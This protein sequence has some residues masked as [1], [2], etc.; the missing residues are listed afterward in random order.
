M[1]NC[2]QTAE[3][4]KQIFENRKK[5]PPLK[6][7]LALPALGQICI[8]SEQQPFLSDFFQTEHPVALSLNVIKIAIVISQ[9]LGMLP[10]LLQ[11]CESPMNSF[12]KH[13]LKIGDLIQLKAENE[14]MQN[15]I[16]NF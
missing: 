11:F 13:N 10:P 8:I 4:C 7:I 16:M 5:L 14:Y 1:E 12:F 3:K 15:F 9:F 2:K 6:H